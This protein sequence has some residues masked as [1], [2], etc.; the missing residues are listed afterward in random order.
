VVV[1]LIVAFIFFTPREFFRDQPRASSIVMLPVAG[2]DE[3]F[4]IE[5]QLLAD[6]DEAGRLTKAGDLLKNKDGKKLDV[7]RVEPL[8]NSEK[9]IIGFAAYTRF[10]K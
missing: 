7:Q 9:E 5:R 4:Y 8:Y 6:L 1:L 3:V 10:R 2:A